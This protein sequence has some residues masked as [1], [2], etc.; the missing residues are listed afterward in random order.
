MNKFIWLL[1]LFYSPSLWELRIETQAN[2]KEQNRENCFL[3]FSLAFSESCAQLA[4]LSIPGLPGQDI[5]NS[6]EERAQ[7]Q[8]NL[9]ET[10]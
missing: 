10:Q 3:A 2:T 8:H 7:N 5:A 1:L 6:M 4:L 9:S